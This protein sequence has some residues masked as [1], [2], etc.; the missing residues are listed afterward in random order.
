[1][2]AIKKIL[3]TLICASTFVYTNGQISSDSAPGKKNYRL[4]QYDS[5]HQKDMI[6]VLT[7][8]FN[9][10][11]P[12]RTS[13]A[14]DST[15]YR[16]HF[17]ALPAA[18]YTLQTGFAAILAA[19]AS[20]YTAKNNATTPS[21]AVTSIAYSQYNQ[22]ILPVNANIYT[23]ND[24]YNIV[25]DW[26]YMKYPS[27][28]F[29]LGGNTDPSSGYTIDFRYIR[30]H[31]YITKSLGHF[32]YAG[33]GYDLD[34]YWK[35]REVDPPQGMVTNFQQYG[36]RDKE[37]A[38]GVSLHGIYDSRANPIYP[39]QGFYASASY[40]PNLTFLGSD[41]NWQSLVVE[42]RKYINLPASTR[43]V[44]AF[45]NY[46]WFTVG[47]KPPYLM[48]PST[49]WDAFSNTG[50][51]YIQG[52]FRGRNMVYFE[53]EYRFGLTPNG[54]LGMVI[55]ANAQS[56]SRLPQQQ[57]QTISPAAGTGLRIKI[58]KFSGSN[59]CIDYGWG[60]NGSKGFFVNLGE[61]F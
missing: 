22:V 61:V 17:S 16:T 51:G 44:L 42:W 33:L 32:F 28:T 57:L 6:D 7:P 45:W 53:S 52:R 4:L 35:I 38:S 56:F 46:N 10:K 21:F 37:V 54:L 59:L 26:R 31:Q 24:G 9:R 11:A 39:I 14:D 19:N 55:F 58:N 49:G 8:I 60:A 29:G 5:L 15:K 50:R 20:F 3:V 30:F 36:L 23:K 48:L 27:T 40:R 2:N 13:E 1:V 18:G 41:A 34:Y 43:N 25:A 47:G 12:L